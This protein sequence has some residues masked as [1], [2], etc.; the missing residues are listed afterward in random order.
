MILRFSV[1]V[2]ALIVLFWPLKSFTAENAGTADASN[3]GQEAESSAVS[4]PEEEKRIKVAFGG[5]ID[6]RLYFTHQAIDKKA[7]MGSFNEIRLHADIR[8]STQFRVFYR[9]YV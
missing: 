7:T 8:Y 3:I 2:F 9:A 4:V 1:A 5:S 6:T